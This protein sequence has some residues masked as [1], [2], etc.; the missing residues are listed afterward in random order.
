MGLISELLNARNK[1][2]Y[3]EQLI[4]GFYRYFF[5][6]KADKMLPEDTFAASNPL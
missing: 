5:S 3:L 4:N 2:Q 1:I 6:S